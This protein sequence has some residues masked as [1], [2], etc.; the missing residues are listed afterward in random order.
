M[1]VKKCQIPTV[2]CGT[3]KMPKTS[4]DG[5]NYYTRIGTPFECMKVG[6]GAGTMSSKSFAKNSLRNI[7]YIGEIHEE[8]FKKSKIS[9]TTQLITRTNK[10][11]RDYIIKLL[12]KILT[13]SDGKI[14]QRAFNSVAIFLYH[15]DIDI[16]ESCKKIKF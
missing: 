11:P 1:T 14:D 10:K 15:N 8:S 7:K 4:K 9:T 6:Y 2:W 16:T 3:S 13:K 12:N 5:Y